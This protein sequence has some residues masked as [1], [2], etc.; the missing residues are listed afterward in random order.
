MTDGNIVTKD[1][2][3]L[4]FANFIEKKALVTELT[5]YG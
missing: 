5:K 2:H 4:Q 3:S 1:R